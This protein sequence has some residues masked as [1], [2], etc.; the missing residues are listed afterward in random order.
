MR[1]SVGKING[2]MRLKCMR[3]TLIRFIRVFLKLFAKKEI[4]PETGRKKEGGYAHK[5]N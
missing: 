1:I 4:C 5:S 2:L 3:Y